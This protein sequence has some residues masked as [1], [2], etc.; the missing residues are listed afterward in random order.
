MSIL[1]LLALGMSAHAADRTA[2]VSD[3]ASGTAPVSDTAPASDM[4][5]VVGGGGGVAALPIGGCNTPY[6]PCESYGQ[7]WDS[8]KCQCVDCPGTPWLF[9]MSPNALANLHNAVLANDVAVR[10][11][12]AASMTVDD[13][14]AF[15]AVGAEFLCA[16]EP[17]YEAPLVADRAQRYLDQ[18]VRGDFDAA[19]DTTAMIEAAVAQGVYSPELGEALVRLAQDATVLP[20]DEVLRQID[21]DLVNRGWK[22]QDA[23]AVTT[24]QAVEHA[25]YSFWG[26]GRWRQPERDRCAVVDDGGA[27]G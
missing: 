19:R 21:E 3:T 23:V 22:G 8:Q 11:D 4:A 26:S 15:L 13:M 17:S 5:L 27:V 9:T 16:Q 18:H 20:A 24:L 10:G 7:V 2:A 25:S 12:A 14:A 1:T 6:I